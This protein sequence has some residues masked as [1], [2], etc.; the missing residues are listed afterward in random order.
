MGKLRQIAKRSV[1][2]KFRWAVRI[3]LQEKTACFWT[4]IVS[5]DLGPRE[6]KSLFGR[7][8]VDLLILLSS[9]FSRQ[10]LIQGSVS[11]LDPAQ[12][13]NVFAFGQLAIDMEISNCHIAI[14]LLDDFL[15]AFLKSLF[16][17]G[18]PPV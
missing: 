16:V 9:R 10:S 11:D 4:S 17:F 13:R 2:S 8:F 18:R 6:K 15:S 1:H 12:I 5:P 7:E 14:E 3:D